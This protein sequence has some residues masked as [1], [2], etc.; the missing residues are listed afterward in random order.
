MWVENM[1]K[2]KYNELHESQ[3]QIM[4]LGEDAHK[5]TT[6]TRTQSVVRVHQATKTVP[7]AIYNHDVRDVDQ[8]IDCV[9]KVCIYI[10]ISSSLPI[11]LA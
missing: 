2:V 3:A 9:R 4:A 1:T 11:F 5:T 6:T 10:R 7:T 8:I